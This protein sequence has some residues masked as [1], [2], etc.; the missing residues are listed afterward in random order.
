MNIDSLK[1]QHKEIIEVVQKIERMLQPQTVEQKSF[2]IAIQIGML[3]GKLLIHL[4]SEDQYLYPALTQHSNKN[5]QLISKRFMS[6]MGTIAEV[7]TKYKTTYMVASNIKAKP[8]QFIADSNKIFETI[9]K[10]ILAED[11]DLYPL[12]N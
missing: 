3:A 12:L 6:E 10:R 11:K 4:K 9:K 1:R 8:E 2:D 7:F 5:I